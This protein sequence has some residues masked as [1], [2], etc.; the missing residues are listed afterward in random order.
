M[1]DETKPH[2]HGVEMTLVEHSLKTWR[3][4]F[5]AIWEGRK[6]HEVR[7][8]D[9]SYGVG[10][11]LLLREWD[12]EEGRYTGRWIRALISCL[13]AGGTWGLPAVL[14]VMSIKEVARNG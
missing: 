7:V 3:E 11:M 1:S 4:P 9:R 10:D 8:N 14:C 12:E 6:C 13:S 2:L 5:D